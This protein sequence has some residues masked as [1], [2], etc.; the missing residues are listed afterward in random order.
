MGRLDTNPAEVEQYLALLAE[1][2]PR[3]AAI[4]ARVPAA[5]LQRVPGS[6]VWAP[7]E[8]LAHLRGCAE[9]WG[10]TMLAMLAE[11]EPALAR[12]DPR[13]W[14]RE[15]G[16]ARL[17]FAA[18]LEGFAQQRAELLGRLQPLP[19]EAWNRGAE[20]GKNRHTVFSQARRMALHEQ[21]HCEQMEAAVLGLGHGAP[22]RA[23][24]P[25]FS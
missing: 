8:I 20:I 22:A 11:A 21:Q 3:L 5:G 1:T 14:A 15:A 4:A 2:P 10:Q 17:P 13:R 6:K 19:F 18:S 24:G 7:V 25:G 9:V 16:Y 23:T 12:H